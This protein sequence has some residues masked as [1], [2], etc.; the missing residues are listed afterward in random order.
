MIA[1][2][3]Y[4]PV[5]C[6]W[7]IFGLGGVCH[8]CSLFLLH[9]VVGIEMLGGG[10]EHVLLLHCCIAELVLHHLHLCC[11]LGFKCLLPLL[12]LSLVGHHCVGTLL[13]EG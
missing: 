12:L 11:H 3:L 9:E 1:P 10:V 2:C 6:G 4:F 7:G 8:L 13:K 5:S